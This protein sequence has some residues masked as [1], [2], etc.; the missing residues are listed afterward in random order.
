M[1]SPFTS[2]AR[3]VFQRANQAALALEHELI[4]TE[5]VLLGILDEPECVAAHVL[6]RLGIDLQ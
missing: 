4:D 3:S 1:F 5:H 6:I 2:R